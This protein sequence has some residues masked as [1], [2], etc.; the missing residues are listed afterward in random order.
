MAS[1]AVRGLNSSMSKLGNSATGAQSKISSAMSMMGKGAGIAA[2]GAAITGMVA[3][4]VVISA[5]FSKGMAEVNTLG[6]FTTEQMDNMGNSLLDMSA[7][8][9]SGLDTA[10]K[11]LYDT[12]SASMSVADSTA[13]LERSFKA[14]VGGSTDASTAVDALSTVINGY[15]GSIAGVTLETDG[16][17][18]V[19]ARTSDLMFMAVNKGKTTFPELAAYMGQVVPTA[20]ALGVGFD[21]LTG[22][23]ATMTKQGIKAANATT[24]I[25]QALTAATSKQEVAAK[26][27]K[28][29]A[30]AFSLQSL[31]S[32]G[33]QQWMV[34]VGNA[35]GN[36]KEKMIK[37]LG[38]SEAMSAFIAMTGVNAKTAAD[39]LAA[40]GDSAG[41]TDRSFKKM[42]NTLIFQ[43]D[44]MAKSSKVL[45]VKL[46]SGLEKALLPVAKAMNRVISAVIEFAGEN[47][48]LVDTVMKTV[49]V[50]GLLVMAV[51]GGMF[52]YGLIAALTLLAPIA[53]AAA[54]PVAIILGVIAA[55]I[56]IGYLL[57][58]AWD[59]NLGGF[60]DSIMES[61]GVLKSAF[62][63][64]AYVFGPLID[65]GKMALEGLGLMGGGLDDTGDSVSVF[66]AIVTALATV[67]GKGLSFMVQLIVFNIK[68]GTTIIKGMIDGIA[69]LIGAVVDGAPKVADALTGAFSKAWDF[70]CKLFRRGAAFVLEM[71]TAPIRG[72][73]SLASKIP[74]I[75][76][77]AERLRE[78]INGVIGDVRGD[79]SEGEPK[80]GAD[81]SGVFDASNTPA[82]AEAEHRET[83]SS[84]SNDAI[85]ESAKSN[86]ALAS[87]VKD[88]SVADKKIVLEVDGEEL[89]NAVS[90]SNDSLAERSFAPG[91]A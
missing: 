40:M 13:F 7:K 16:M 55:V 18:K 66:G 51:G 49:A 56:A 44:K 19:V 5:S 70:I 28:K 85:R 50:V 59:E 34:D 84:E 48:K 72:L 14:S 25:K 32:K 6:D 47:P 57:K 91:G 12:L 67:V 80:T 2:A 63:D 21:Q 23:Y 39:D 27:G 89:A 15:K 68:L 77:H 36:S 22:A 37:L 76:K 69:W 26:M 43:S 24:L 73:L 61:W 62:S 65:V 75:G 52:I 71:V 38:S 1:G 58:K 30:D 64:L 83:M 4:P 11:S 29:V 74:G 17:A 8:Y 90:R 10:T 31:R 82:I 9:A 81:S 33:L 79:M 87:I 88:A 45:A 53:L 20:N 42:S 60:K 86:Y 46:G 3:A 41:V 78:S 35:V 54:A